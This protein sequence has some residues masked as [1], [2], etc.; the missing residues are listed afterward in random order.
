MWVAAIK[1]SPMIPMFTSFIRV[2][3][4]RTVVPFT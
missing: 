4:S 2:K 1:P 3:D